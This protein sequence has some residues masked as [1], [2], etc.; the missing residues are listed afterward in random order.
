MTNK[1]SVDYSQ[2]LSSGKSLS[3]VK[4]QNHIKFNI[5]QEIC[6]SVS[7]SE[8][9]P[10]RIKQIVFDFAWNSANK[11]ALKSFERHGSLKAFNKR[12][13]SALFTN[14]ESSSLLIFS[15]STNF[16]HF[17]ESRNKSFSFCTWIMKKILEIPQILFFIISLVSSDAIFFSHP[18]FAV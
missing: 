1:S 7:L 5:F 14:F 3:R 4:S 18:R 13:L 15:I 10:R 11:I 2:K 8:Q 6:F 17:D 9:F 12:L 16:L